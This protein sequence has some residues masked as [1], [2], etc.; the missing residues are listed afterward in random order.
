ML[1]KH[2][3]S[4]HGHIHK[5]YEKHRQ[6]KKQQNFSFV[7]GKN[8]ISTCCRKKTAKI[9]LEKAIVVCL[10]SNIIIVYSS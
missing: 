5:L 7:S 1:F 4:E 9:I 6:Q 8:R 2:F 3:I 10:S